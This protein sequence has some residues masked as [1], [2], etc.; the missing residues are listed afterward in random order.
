M[1]NSAPIEPPPPADEAETP[2]LWIMPLVNVCLMQFGLLLSF[3]RMPQMEA[4]TQGIAA[5]VL[6][7]WFVFL[8]PLTS[9]IHLCT[10][11]NRGFRS[12][13]LAS[14]LVSIACLGLWGVVVTYFATH[15]VD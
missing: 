15:P 2:M 1:W 9:T 4:R 8:L 6:F 14:A 13:A 10:A 3:V 12:H 5:V 7:I 11:L